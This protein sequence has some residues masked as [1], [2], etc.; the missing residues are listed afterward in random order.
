ML[1]HAQKPR[2]LE[3]LPANGIWWSVNYTGRILS[4]C[5]LHLFTE[6][7]APEAPSTAFL[8]NFMCPERS[9]GGR[10]SDLPVFYWLLEGQRFS[11]GYIIYSLELYLN[12]F[13]F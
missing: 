5:L 2:H 1:A 11:D 9:L 7:H 12:R 10:G 13:V 3:I 4:I 6:T 8:M